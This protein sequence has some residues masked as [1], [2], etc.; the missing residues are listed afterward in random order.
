M[1][2]GWTVVDGVMAKALRRGVDLS[3]FDLRQL[4]RR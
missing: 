3:H 4:I 2:I 1:R